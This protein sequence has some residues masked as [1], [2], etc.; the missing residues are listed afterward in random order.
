MLYSTVYRLEANFEYSIKRTPRIQYSG[1]LYYAIYTR[2]KLNPEL[3][4]K[5]IKSARSK[6]YNLL[7]RIKRLA[8]YRARNKAESKKASGKRASGKN[9]HPKSYI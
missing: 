7:E 9:Y 3:K 6:A 8:L 2:I 1:K 4:K 5:I